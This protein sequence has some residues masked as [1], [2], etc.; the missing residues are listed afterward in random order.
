MTFFPRVLP[1]PHPPSTFY[2]SPESMLLGAVLY[3]PASVLRLMPEVHSLIESSGPTDH[4]T[5]IP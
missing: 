4:G 3:Y 5:D 1:S 2:I